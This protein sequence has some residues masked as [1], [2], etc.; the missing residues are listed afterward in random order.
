MSEYPGQE[1][2]DQ[3]YGDQGY[4]GQSY[5][6]QSSQESQDPSQTTQGA[7]NEDVELDWEYS[8]EESFQ[9]SMD[10]LTSVGYE[11]P[12]G[13]DSSPDYVA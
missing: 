1:S 3:S 8:T 7:E 2:G 5:S 4:G 10:D 6:D 9:Y 11:P 13:D 12:S